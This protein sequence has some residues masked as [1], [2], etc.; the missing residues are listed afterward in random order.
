[1]FR[2]VVKG[3]DLPP[4]GGRLDR[5]EV[6]AKIHRPER[7]V[8]PCR[9]DLHLEGGLVLR[10]FLVIVLGAAL[11]V[12]GGVMSKSTPAKAMTGICAYQ[13]WNKD[14]GFNRD[15]V[16]RTIRCAVAHY[17]VK[18]GASKALYIAWR[19]SRFNPYATNGSFKG[20]YQQ[21]TT[22]WPDRYRTYGFSYLKNKILNAR[23]NIIVSIRMAHRHGWGPWGG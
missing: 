11:L 10:R 18:G 23:T 22:W 2:E 8:G 5:E 16:K 17:P 13:W 1:V 9:P 3:A 4:P 20:V 6:V 19:E 15:A 14:T 21:G 12:S 7:R